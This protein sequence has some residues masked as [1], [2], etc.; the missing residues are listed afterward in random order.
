[1]DDRAQADGVDSGLDAAIDETIPLPAVS[2]DAC[3]QPVSRPRRRLFGGWSREPDG[4]HRPDILVVMKPLVVVIVSQLLFTAGDLIARLKMRQLGFDADA[5]VSWWFAGYMAL[6][7]LAT[8]GQLWVLS[9]LVLGHALPM[10]AASSVV[11]SMLLSVTVLSE[12]LTT[13]TVIGGGLAVA[14]L[15][16]L[17]L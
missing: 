14:S 5:F 13:K 2:D 10:F 7:T 11:L 1:V 6:R 9:K 16:A 3:R 15:V 4:V 17:T 12:G 8:F